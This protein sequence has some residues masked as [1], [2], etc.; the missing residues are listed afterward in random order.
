MAS[1]PRDLA[2][3]HAQYKVPTAVQAWQIRIYKP[4]RV[5]SRT[6]IRHVAQLMT[7]DH[8]HHV[9]VWVRDFIRRAYL[10]KTG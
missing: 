9:I 7:T 10:P 5:P 4:V 1:S 6:S 2:S 8:I 3:F